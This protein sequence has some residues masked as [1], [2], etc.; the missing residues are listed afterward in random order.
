M[1]PGEKPDNK[2]TLGRRADPAT[3]VERKAIE[4]SVKIGRNIYARAPRSRKHRPAHHSLSRDVVIREAHLRVESRRRFKYLVSPF[5]SPPFNPLDR[6]PGRRG[7]PP[8]TPGELA[9]A[10]A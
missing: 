9:E 6:G 3:P 4:T 10:L 7:C 5:V 2:S 1:P 8:E